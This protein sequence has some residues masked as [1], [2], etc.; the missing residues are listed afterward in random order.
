MP[1]KQSLPEL[2]IDPQDGLEADISPSKVKHNPLIG[3]AAGICSGLTKLVVGHPFDTIKTRL[4]CTPPGT[5]GGAWHCFTKTIS[6]EGPRALYKGA[7]VPAVSWGITD[8]ILMGS[9]HN[10]RSILEHNGFAERIP[11][12]VDDGPKGQ[13]LSILGHTVAGAMAGWTNA[14]IA[15]PTEVIKCRLQLQM[16]LPA[17]VPKQYS[18]PFD[19][20]RQTYQA[21]GATGMWRGVGASFI[22]RTCFAAMFGGFEIFNR[23]FKRWDGTSWQMSEAARNFWA[24]GLAS[25]LYWATALPLDNVKNRLMV[26]K[27]REPRFKGVI[28]AYSQTWRETYDGSKSLLWNSK[29]RI[30]N[31]YRGFV[32][33]ALRAFPT[34]AAALAVWE[35]L[36]RYADGHDK[37]V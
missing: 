8:S 31:F 22:Y 4:Q 24:G 29:A 32:P 2:D 7:S 13:R 1:G 26:D 23:M 36:M 34:N 27:L 11:G 33:V 37:I 6:S 18:G 17:D 12:S 9:L 28:N 16:V 21:L 15:H 30:R 10:Y 25:N 19:V 20:V 35:A 5:F 3:F 14:V